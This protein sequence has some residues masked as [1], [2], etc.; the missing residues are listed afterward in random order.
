MLAGL[1]ITVYWIP[2]TRSKNGD[3]I[4]LEELAEGRPMPNKFSKSWMAVRLCAMYKAC[5]GSRVKNNEGV[6][7]EVQESGA[8]GT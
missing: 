7:D 1:F 8:T 3:S 6:A 5:V 2:E 4:P